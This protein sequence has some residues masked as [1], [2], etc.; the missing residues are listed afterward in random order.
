MIAI[1]EQTDMGVTKHPGHFNS[2]NA[3]YKNGLTPFHHSINSTLILDQ[4]GALGESKTV[5]KS[6]N[7]TQSFSI[8]SSS[9]SLSS[10]LSSAAPS[11]VAAEDVI[12]G[13]FRDPCSAPPWLLYRLS[14]DCWKRSLR[15]GILIPCLAKHL[16]SSVDSSQG[17]GDLGKRFDDRW[18]K[19]SIAIWVNVCDV[20]TR[21]A[22][23]YG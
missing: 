17:E 10:F 15:I 13:A 19:K 11:C 22:H 4:H 20:M 7:L 1:R 23:A 16:E 21:D 9:S 8:P 6:P 3:N 12:L 2:K 18:E 14:V 5:R